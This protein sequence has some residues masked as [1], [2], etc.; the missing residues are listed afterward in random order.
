MLANLEKL[1]RKIVIKIQHGDRSAFKQ[2]FHRYK[3]KLFVYVLAIVKRE[4]VA[5][6]IVQE[7]FIRLWTTR[8]NLDPDQSLSGYLHTIAR[9]QSLNHLKRAG[10][11]KKLKQK[12]WETIDELQQQITIE[13]QLFALESEKLI[14]KAVDRL[15]PQRKLVFQLSRNKHMTH[16]EIAE[17]LG[18]S[19][20]TVKNQIVTALKEIR[21]YLQKHSDIALLWMFAIATFWF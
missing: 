8:E 9:N 4:A 18:V 5:K 13:E 11:D 12:I 1:E 15:S 17:K 19:K 6:D 3:D 10:Y 16:K 2:I 20:N 7:T 14:A 21:A